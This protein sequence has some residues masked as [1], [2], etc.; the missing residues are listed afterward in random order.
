VD[1]MRKPVSIDDDGYMTLDLDTNQDYI[2]TKWYG[3]S[4]AV[5]EEEAFRK[6]IDRISTT[7]RDNG[8]GRSVIR[9][10]LSAAVTMI[11]RNPQ[12]G[13]YLPEIFQRYALRRGEHLIAVSS[14]DYK[15]YKD[16]MPVMILASERYVDNA[17]RQTIDKHTPKAKEI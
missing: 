10:F 9:F 12:G 7:F 8:N 17:M 1:A 4:I 2:M 5:F 6:Y 16:L 3:N 14:I 15:Y 11:D 13:W